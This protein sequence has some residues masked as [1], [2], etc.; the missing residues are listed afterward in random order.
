[1]M[2]S[3]AS[4]L[5]ALDTYGGIIPRARDVQSFFNFDPGF[6]WPITLIPLGRPNT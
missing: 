1:M 5:N 3:S 2:F 6:H 4:G